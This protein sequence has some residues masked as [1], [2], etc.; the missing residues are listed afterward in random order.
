M[1]FSIVEVYAL[2]FYLCKREA[3]DSIARSIPPMTTVQL[4]VAHCS[5]LSPR[6]TSNAV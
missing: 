4:Y 1:I 5:L 3:E 2:V 6:Y